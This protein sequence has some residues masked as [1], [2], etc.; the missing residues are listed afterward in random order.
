MPAKGRGDSRI[1]ERA[2]WG[3]REREVVLPRVDRGVTGQV[4][5][6]ARGVGTRA[7]HSNWRTERS[8]VVIELDAAAGVPIGNIHVSGEGH[9]V[10]TNVKTLREHGGDELG[11]RGRRRREH[12]VER[13]DEGDSEY[14]RDASNEPCARSPD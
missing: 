12:R 3:K 14:D 4:G 2:V 11:R 8:R 6:A 13:E 9:R 1:D 7:G 10:P 5:D